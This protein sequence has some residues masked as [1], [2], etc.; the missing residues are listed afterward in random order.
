MLHYRAGRLPRH[1]AFA[2]LVAVACGYASVTP[3]AAEQTT[4]SLAG[5]WEGA[6]DANGGALPFSVSFEP[7]G[8]TYAGAIDVKAHRG[9]PLAAIRVAGSQ[10]HFELQIAKPAVAVFDGA[11]DG[12]TMSGSFSQGRARGSFR[13]KRVAVASTAAGDGT[14]EITWS[15]SGVTL[16][17]TLTLPRGPHKA[18]FRAIV[19]VSGSG[20][21]NRDSD[22]AGF[23]LFAVL[24]DHLTRHGIAVLRYDD[25]GVGGS[26]GRLATSTLN[27]LT[28]DVV[29]AVTLL[30]TRADID[31]RHI[32]ILGH[33][34]G[35]HVA[36]LT[37]LA[38]PSVAF[39]V[40]AAP[41]ARPGS[42]ILRRQQADA[43]LAMGASP[44][45]VAAVQKA[46]AKVVDAVSSNASPAVLEAA[47]R[48]Q[49]AAQADARPPAGRAL[50]GDRATFVE[51]VLPGALAQIQSPAMRELIAFDPLPV[52]RKLQ[53]PTL[54]LFGGKD[55]QVPPDDNRPAFESAFADAGQVRPRVILYPEAN[56]LLM[57]AGS[58]HPAGV[59][60]AAESLRRDAARRCHPLDCCPAL[61]RE[62]RR[63]RGDGT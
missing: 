56:H 13:L 47:V 26:T 55:M 58:G 45:D 2:T 8:D 25:R 32:G 22:I 46:F 3:S 43:A 29:A 10:V 7:V 24:A 54:A 51:K 34:Q 27:D 35:A 18:P 52:F 16:S 31:G 44:E 60:I 53:R 33:S 61:T 21:Q 17:G 28:G 1:L 63:R 12:D 30:A 48:E 49:I 15:N 39:L 37:A 11:I 42:E 62:R 20:P 4:P 36:A 59:R 38:A 5:R 14:E 41:P 23:K 57:A 6:I 50:I 40:L 19:L 9:S